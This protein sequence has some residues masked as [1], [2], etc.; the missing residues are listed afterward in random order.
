MGTWD[1]R[2]GCS[3]ALET[4]TQVAADI[5]RSGLLL[6]LPLLFSYMFTLSSER[7]GYPIDFVLH[8]GDISY[9]DGRGCI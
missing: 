1:T 8:I 4:T 2:C 6:S 9:A 5:E 7:S 3:G